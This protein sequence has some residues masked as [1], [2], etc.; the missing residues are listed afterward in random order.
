[1]TLS[2]TALIGAVMMTVSVPDHL[3]TLGQSDKHEIHEADGHRDFRNNPTKDIAPLLPLADR[4]DLGFIPVPVYSLH[5]LDHAELTLEGEILAQEENTPFRYG[6][7]RK[8][9][10]TDQD[11]IWVNVPG[12]RLWQ[13]E[14]RAEDA[15]NVMIKIEDMNLPKGA[16]LRSYDPNFPESVDGPYSEEGPCRNGTRSVWTHIRPVDSII[17]EYFEPKSARTVNGL[18]FQI[19]ELIHGYLPVLKD[20]LAGGSGSCHN[21]ATCYSS[22]EDE[23]DAEALVFFSG[24]LCSGQLIAT[25]NQDQTAYYLTAAHCIS[26]SSVANGAQFV[27]K[28]ERL[29]CTGSVYNGLA[30]NGSTLI[31]VHG[32]SDHT[33]LRINGSLP[34]SV[35]WCGWTTDS[36]GVN[37]PVTCLH[38]PAGDRMKYSTGTVNSNPVCGSSTYWFGV[39]WNDGVTEGGSSGS[40]AY[41]TSDKKLMGV[42]TC[43]ASSCSNQNGLDGY[44]RFQRAYSNGG[45]DEYLELGPPGDDLYEDNDTCSSAI[46]MSG[47]G[48]FNDLIVKSKDEDWFRVNVPGGQ[49]INFDLD[50]VDSNGDI[51]IELYSLSCSGDLVDEGDSN[52]NDES[53]EWSNYESTSK[54]I[55][56]RIF[57]YD[58][59]ENEYDMDISFTDNPEPQGTCC[60]GT[61]CFL[62]TQTNCV[63]GGGEWGGAGS[64][65]DANS[66]IDPTGA[67]C[68]GEECLSLSAEICGLAGGSYNGD[69]STECAECGGEEPCEADSNGD[70]VV[71]GVDLANLLA[72]WGTP[73]GDLTGDEQT[74]GQDLALVLASW[75]ACS[76]DEG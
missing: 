74:D 40:A 61:T 43:G 34:N 36:A 28:Y 12:G 60:V 26:S 44:G 21:E 53:V 5:P 50:F 15:E 73:D 22:W 54:R 49:T 57:L 2:T 56:A 7:P 35:F 1:M 47:E 10:I 9:D 30:V 14:V 69:G 31:D 46:L 62:D 20:G 11:G 3:P 67:C 48:S 27:F 25:S 8:L 64:T 66:C 72:R 65:C 29:N 68:V 39:R 23:G 38:H 37:T 76:G 16:E 71:D 24:S 18:P 17:I 42:L 55:F 63:A 6:V 51:D 59:S 75:G 70:G 32:S 52:T 58:G 4:M 33:L 19:T 45:F 13:V 41:R